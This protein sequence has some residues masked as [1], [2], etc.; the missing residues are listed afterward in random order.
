MDPLNVYLYVQPSSDSGA[1]TGDRRKL[2][3]MLTLRDELVALGGVHV[4]PA[5]Q[6]ADL[7][8]EIMNLVGH[9][10]A[11]PKAKPAPRRDDAHRIL[12]VRV[13]VEN[14]RLDFVCSDGIGH[15]TAESQAAKRIHAWMG[16]SPTPL[17][18]NTPSQ[19]A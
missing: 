2:Q 18:R 17:R 3:S 19:Y 1:S 10:D 9:S 16:G 7:Q 15:M 12:I 14:E 5:P 8:V 13:Q 4:A 11:R 6:V